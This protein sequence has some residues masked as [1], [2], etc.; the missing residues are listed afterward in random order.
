MSL[1]LIYGFLLVGCATGIIGNPTDKVT[2][3]K[4][5]ENLCEVLVYDPDLPIIS[6]EIPADN[7]VEVRL[8]GTIK[9]M[10]LTSNVCNAFP[11]VKVI[12]AIGIG[13]KEVA[14]DAFKGCS[15]LTA[16]YLDNNE[17]SS[18]DNSLF[19]SNHLLERLE[20]PNNTIKTFD[21][22]ILNHTPKLQL[23]FLS[24]NGMENFILG[25]LSTELTELRK[26]ELQNNKLKSLNLREFKKHFPYL[27]I[28]VMCYRDFPDVDAE[29]LMT[30]LPPEQRFLSLND[31][32]SCE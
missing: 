6:E 14:A 22:S 18:L 2:C 15:K 27:R 19:E 17:I 1:I 13:L 32:D 24:D 10:K 23:M 8:N 11:N 30:D 4:V 25:D 28:L 31:F 12:K 29:K 20:L 21:T 9:S 26:I 3:N 7:I 5:D 16:I